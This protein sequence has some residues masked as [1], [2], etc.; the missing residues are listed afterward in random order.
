MTADVFVG[1]VTHP[2][3]RFTE[4]SGELGVLAQ[5]AASL[6]ALGRTVTTFIS[7]RD[8][9]S[10]ELVCIDRAAVSA[11]ICAELDSEFRWREYLLG[12]K[13]GIALRSLMFMRK[14]WRTLRLM[15]L[16]RHHLKPS[17]SGFQMVRRL[18]NIELSHLVLMDQALESGAP[19]CLLLEDDAGCSDIQQ[20]AK[21]LVTMIEMVEGADGPLMVSLSESFSLEDLG[22]KELVEPVLENSSP[23]PMLAAIR[24]VTNTVCA[25]LYRRRFLVRLR[26]ELAAIPMTPV[27]PIDFKLNEALMRLAPSLQ[28]GAAWL[29]SPAPLDQLSGVPTVRA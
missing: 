24:P 4:A 11:S 29:A 21:D 14:K 26:E 9:Y 10:A 18:V 7:E 12:R 8:G 5:T 23:W 19:W 20:F 25:V 16:G 3:S 2:R 13:A 28:P 1:L 22:I 6:E 17:D 27:I 15:P